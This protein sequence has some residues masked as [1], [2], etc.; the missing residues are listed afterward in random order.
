MIRHLFA[1]MIAFVPSLT[2]ASEVRVLA[3]VILESA[4]PAKA[5]HQ[6]QF[7]TLNCLFETLVRTNASSV[8]VAGLAKRWKISENGTLYTFSLSR[9]KFSDGTLVTSRDVAYSISRHFWPH[10]DSV[11]KEVLAGVITGTE[12]LAPGKIATGLATPKADTIAIKLTRP[13]TLLLTLLSVPGFGIL[14]AGSAEAGHVIGSGPM[15]LKSLDPSSANLTINQEHSKTEVDTIRF[16][17]IGDYKTVIDELSH[18]NADLAL[19]FADPEMEKLVPSSFHL[20]R[21]NT[22]GT[23]HLYYNLENSQLQNSSFRKDLSALLLYGFRKEPNPGF[24]L[25]TLSTFLP[26]GLMPQLYYNKTENVLQPADFKKRW[27]ANKLEHPLEI[28]LR[29]EYLNPRTIDNVM[30]ALNEGGV[31]AKV[32]QG[33]ISELMP[34][35]KDKKYDML[36][37]GYFGIAPDPDGFLSPLR[38]NTIP[39]YGIMPTRDLFEKLAEIRFSQQRQY[40][41]LTYAKTLKAFEDQSYFL[42]LYRLFFPAIVSNKIRLPETSYRFEMEL[43]KIERTGS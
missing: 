14:K 31:P 35:L 10:S 29:K 1:M 43:Y 16:K 24:F 23:L 34:R 26:A 15:I 19:G 20:Y 6:I 18:S 8:V 3:P 38:E 27:P 36:M 42:P 28:Y 21:F 41:L 4:D 9:S 11:I 32:T 39:R 7:L 30:N 40:R 13:Y 5:W 37:M 12:T 2:R 33:Y 25:Q 22:L 17:R